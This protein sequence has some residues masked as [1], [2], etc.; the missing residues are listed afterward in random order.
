MS[1]DYHTVFLNVMGLFDGEWPLR[2]SMEKY[3]CIHRL[4]IYCQDALEGTN[5]Q[6]VLEKIY[7]DIPLVVDDL[8]KEIQD[9]EL[10]TLSLGY[11]DKKDTVAWI[12][13]QIHEYIPCFAMEAL[14]LNNSNALDANQACQEAFSMIRN[15]FT[16]AIH[17][18]IYGQTEFI[19]TLES[20]IK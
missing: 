13:Q 7:E 3:G 15:H 2:E 16:C 9:T 4:K 8:L 20:S 12:V 1:E 11:L 18:K 19:A 6:P 5:N 17:Q 14:K 10:Q